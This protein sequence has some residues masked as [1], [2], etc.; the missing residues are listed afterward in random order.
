MLVVEDA[1]PPPYTRDVVW[2]LDDWLLDETRQIFDRFNTPHDLMHDGRWGN[3]VTVN[4]RTD[5]ALAARGG[6][7][8]RL[9]LLNASNARIYAPDFGA[10][11]PHIIAVDGL[12]LARP[13]PLGRFEL[14]P[15]NRLDLDVT[16]PPAAISRPLPVVDRFYPDDAEPPRRR[17]RRRRDRAPRPVVPHRR[18]TRACRRGR[19]ASRSRR[20]RSSS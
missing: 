18:R 14:A 13:I 6:E 3:F 2:V 20:R 1:T 10:L 15:G 19:R 12:Y 17:R 11:E 9:R 16:L 4:G 5:T 7:R 8:I